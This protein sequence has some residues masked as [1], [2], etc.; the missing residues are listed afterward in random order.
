MPKTLAATNPTRSTHETTA[1][2]TPTPF[3]S[4][5]PGALLVMMRLWR[6]IEKDGALK[7]GIL[8]QRHFGH[9]EEGIDGVHFIAVAKTPNRPT[10]AEGVIATQVHD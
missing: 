10:T 9:Q 7:F 1:V 4:G 8:F 3:A 5:H 6:A 2:A